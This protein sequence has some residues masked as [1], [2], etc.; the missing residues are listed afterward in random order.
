MSN[1][2]RRP[3]EV[4]GEARPASAIEVM[5]PREVPLGGPR[6]M[7]VRRTL[8]QRQRSLIGAWCFLDHYGPDD[9]ASTGGMR[10]PGHP[11]TGLQT[12]SWL[13]TGEVEH[14]DTTGVHAM[15]RPGE[16]NLM[17]AGS[18]IAH[19]EFSTPSTSVLHGAQ[20]WLALP[21]ATRHVAPT[22]EH[23]APPAVERPGATARVFLGGLLGSL[24]P[25]AT[26][27]PLLGAEIV[28]DAGASLTLDAPAGL[29][30]GFEH[31]LL[32]DIGGVTVRAEGA[33]DRETEDRET[34][35]SATG[36]SETVKAGGRVPVERGELAYL[37]VGLGEVTITAADDEPARVLLLGGEPFGEQ[38]VMWWNF[39]GRTHDEVVAYREAW[40]RERVA[41]DDAGDADGADGA[42]GG[43]EDLDR[44][45]GPFPDAWDSTLPAPPM[46]PLRLRSRG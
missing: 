40:E 2:E 6:A 3:G 42:P 29:Q 10:V 4:M 26:H 30:P 35:D 32:V 45:Y 38:I 34:E 21:D 19:S 5:T 23:Y 43:G 44:R 20:L 17:T 27:S 18:G 41:A 37:P 24:S 9:V 36:D 28:L 13:F 15:V 12:V 16:L 7:T 25:V 46:P 33:E 14:R 1:P 39:I 22:F 11:H 31:G 8:P